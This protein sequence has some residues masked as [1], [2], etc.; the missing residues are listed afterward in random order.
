MTKYIGASE[1]TVEI[2]FSVE[3]KGEELAQEAA[4]YALSNWKG[5]NIEMPEDIYRDVAGTFSLG[6][7]TITGYQEPYLEPEAAEE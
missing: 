2:R 6:R 5:A 4:E 3:A 1:V 7:A